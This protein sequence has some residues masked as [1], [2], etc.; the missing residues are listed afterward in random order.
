[1][2]ATMGVPEDGEARAALESQMIARF[3]LGRAGEPDDVAKVVLFLASRASDY[4]TGSLVLAD[5]GNLLT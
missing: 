5:G 2:Q 3:P 1:M 4:M